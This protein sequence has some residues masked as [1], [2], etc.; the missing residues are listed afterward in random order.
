MA[1]LKA[2]QQA[3]PDTEEARR[4]KQ[5]LRLRQEEI[6]AVR[7]ELAEAKRLTTLEGTEPPHGDV[8][9]RLTSPE[10]TPEPVTYV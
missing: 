3:E 4:L 8:S 10:P 6:K 1:E 9:S 2:L 7:T 5:E